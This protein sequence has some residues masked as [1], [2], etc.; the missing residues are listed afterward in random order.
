MVAN[1]VPVPAAPSESR[2][3]FPNE[4]SE[5]APC[6]PSEMRERVP[7]RTMGA[8]IASLGTPIGIGVL[9]PMLGEL[10]ATIELVVVLTVIGTA[11]FG[12]P[13]LS[14][15]AFRLLRWFGNQPEP[16]GPPPGHPDGGQ[17]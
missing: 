7:W 5:Q 6:G 13:T 3:V 10:I 15:R 1:S 9:H 2:A 17:T 12:S 16:P 14:E 8:G 4:G 11:L